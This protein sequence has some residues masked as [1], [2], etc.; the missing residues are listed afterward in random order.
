MN[1]RSDELSFKEGY[2]IIP[3]TEIEPKDFLIGGA[4]INKG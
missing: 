1:V 3:E 4:Y 2:L